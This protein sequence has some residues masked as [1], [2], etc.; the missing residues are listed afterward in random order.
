MILTASA[1]GATRFGCGPNIATP[2]STSVFWARSMAPKTW[3]LVFDRTRTCVRRREQLVNQPTVAPQSFVGAAVP[4]ARHPLA[5]AARRGPATQ[6]N[7]LQGVGRFTADALPYFPTLQAKN[8][9]VAVDYLH[10]PSPKA[11]ALTYAGT[12]VWVGAQR[13]ETPDD[14]ARLA[15]QRCEYESGGACVL[16]PATST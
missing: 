3:G 11:I 12:V 1:A 5:D 10:G 4:H 9:P 16:M 15:V 7:F 6:V 13:N 8:G 2:L 14:V